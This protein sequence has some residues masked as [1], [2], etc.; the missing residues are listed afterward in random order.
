[1]RILLMGN[2]N[3]GKSALFSRLTGVDVIISNYP[4]TTIEFKKGEM[5]LD[6]RTVEVIDVPG[7][8]TLEPTSK[9]EEVA[10]GMLEEEDI[11]INVV[12]ATN[13]ERNLYLTLQLLE[14]NIPVVVVLNFW[15][16][17][18]H[19][20]IRIDAEKLE[21]HL[22]VPVVPA[23]AVTGVG[24]KALVSRLREARSH[25]NSYSEEA[26][27]G[28]IGRI[29]SKV[30][31]VTLKKH[32]FLE[33][34]EDMSVKPLTG[35]PMTLFILAFVFWT[36]R[37]VGENLITYLFD[38][39]FKLYLPVINNL[40]EMLGRGGI[41][42]DILIGTLI[43]GKID[44]VQSMGLLTTGL[45]VPFAMVLPYI[46]AFYLV[47]GVMEDSGYLPRLATLVDAVLHKL[48]MHGLAIIP[49]L[50][51]FGCNVPGALS[52][53][54]LETR[55]QRFIAATLMAIAV[56][57]MAQTSMVFALLGPYG[58]KGLGIYFLTLFIVWL[59]L[60][61]LLNRG[62][63]G[64]TP[65][66]FMEIPPYRVPYFGSLSKKLWMRMRGFLR[67]AIPFV[68]LGVLIV[69][70]LYVFGIIG[71][72]SEAAS[73][74]IVGMLG[75]PKE[76]VASL[77]VGFLRKDVAVGML[78][79]LGLD[80]GQLIVASVVLTMYFPCVATF[81]VLFKELGAKDLI[82][83]TAIM[84]VSTLLVGSILNALL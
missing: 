75:L 33:N 30:Q 40:S 12:D 6:D 56:P 57:C 39:L 45:Y 32:T 55:K 7:T 65:E 80:M 11:V 41:I 79:P 58:I 22:D 74:V 78:L 13:L 2:P 28:E 37:F 67:E 29:V 73:P 84:V 69:N 42:H 44:Y 82:K 81:V 19:L 3:V 15:D 50:L 36:V 47:L 4:G 70:I 31:K 16:E 62:I 43:E 60:G 52:T 63:K 17:I 21:A 20:G 72:I 51:G 76:A 46:F 59:A 8:Y 23:V 48:G 34:L 38:P 53:R 5:K 35:I 71:W 1:M 66:T 64:E 24:I 26:R 27:W 54:I 14:R 10:V 77:I 83:A 49:T 18:R 61:F 9:A 68:L 25:T